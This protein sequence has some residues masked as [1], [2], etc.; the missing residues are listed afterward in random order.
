MSEKTLDYSKD[1]S[2]SSAEQMSFKQTFRGDLSYMKTSQYRLSNEDLI[3]DKSY[4][5]M[6]F[7]RLINKVDSTLLAMEHSVGYSTLFSKSFSNS[8]L[9]SRDHP[10]SNGD[11]LAA[12]GWLG[13]SC[14]FI[15]N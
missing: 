2:T 9:I 4:I 11:K 7:P 6:C 8:F 14:N 15:C 5:Y 3:P 10:K 1:F 13:K 12:N